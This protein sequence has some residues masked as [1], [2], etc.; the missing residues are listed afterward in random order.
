MA[1]ETVRK[2]NTIRSGKVLMVRNAI[3]KK[4][5]FSSDIELWK[6]LPRR[7]SYLSLKVILQHLEQQNKIM[8]DNDGSIVWIYADSPRAR[9]SLA[10]SV[11]L[12]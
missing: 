8:R 12:R 3:K 2:Y 4:Q 6:S 5:I 11:P 7:I 10:K 9:R 1:Q